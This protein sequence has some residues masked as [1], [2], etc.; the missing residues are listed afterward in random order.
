MEFID[1]AVLPQSYHHLELVRYLLMLTFVLFMPYVS[2]LLGTLGYSLWFDRKAVTAGNKDYSYLSKKMIDFATGGKGM[3]YGLGIVPLVSALFGYAQLLHSN[4]NVVLEALF[5]AII[6]LAVALVFLYKYKA[7]L[8]Y[9]DLLKVD[10]R[11]DQ[12][13]LKEEAAAMRSVL[14]KNYQKHGKRALVFLLLSVLLV[15]SVISSVSSLIQLEKTTNI[16]GLMFSISTW[17]NFI[18]LLFFSLSIGSVVFVYLRKDHP[19]DDISEVSEKKL[20]SG[21]MQTGIVS[22]IL[23]L[24]FLALGMILV[25]TEGKSENIFILFVLLAIVSLSISSMYYLMIKDG[26]YRF[27]NASLFFTLTLIILFVVKDNIAFAT[28]ADKHFQ[29]MNAEYE[30]HHSEMLASMGVAAVEISGED[31][32]NGKCIACHQ[33]DKKVVGPPYNSVLGKYEGKQEDLV[34][35][36]LNPQKIDTN[37]PAMPNQGLKPNEARAIAEYIVSVY[38]QSGTK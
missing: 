10:S 33:F 8:H 9:K 28:S 11:Y 32:Y 30:V 27:A 20:Q 26:N 21:I 35:Y 2:I 37:Y 31:I 24:V 29:V 6:L 7:D 23:S 1:G 14:Q 3:P 22:T 13:Y 38:K 4:S 34:K 18:F 5:V 19:A 36:I 25:P 12:T 17:V 15:I 16:F